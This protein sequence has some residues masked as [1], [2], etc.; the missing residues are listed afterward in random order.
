M[1]GDTGDLNRSYFGGKMGRILIGVCLRRRGDTR[2]SDQRNSGLFTLKGS[3]KQ[4][5]GRSTV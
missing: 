2:D 1:W 3:K 4:S 5:G